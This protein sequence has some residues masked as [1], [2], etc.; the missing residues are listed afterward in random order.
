[1]KRKVAAYC[2]VST[3]KEIQLYS[4]EIQKQYYKNLIEANEDFLFVGIY[5]DTASGLKKKDRVQFAKLL[6]DCKKKKID[7]IYTKSISRFARNTLD[8]LEVIRKLK[9]M[10]VDV[11]FENERIW[12]KN[13]RSELTMTIYA[14]VAQEESISKSRITRWGLVSGFK[15]GTSRLANRV[16]YGYKQDDEGNLIIDEEEARN[17]KLIF[18]LY[19]QG[20]SLSRISKELYKRGIASPTGKETWTSA[21]IDKLLGNE[22]YIG[23]ALL[24]KTHV[25]NVLDQKQKKNNGEVTKY[26][27]EN[28]HVE[29]IDV[30]TFEAVQAEKVRR[31]NIVSNA[32]GKQVRKNTRHSSGNS[33]SGKIKCGECGC[34]YRRITTHSGEI[35]WRCAGRVEKSGTC[36][37]RT[38]KQ[39]EIDEILLEEFGVESAL[40]DIYGIV[41]SINVGAD[42]IISK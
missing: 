1:M 17:V 42:L 33:L 10:G 20:Y 3:K 37:A 14:T 24:Q 5:A 6:K 11:Y 40:I 30:E 29:I 23:Q 15:S 25:P 12:L 7:I 9:K 13:E 22:K 27:Y 21:A 4:L 38:V 35:V 26:L 19:L 18:D 39:S 36:K 16:C 31:T 2:R 41:K 8:F 32:R 28:N 34:N